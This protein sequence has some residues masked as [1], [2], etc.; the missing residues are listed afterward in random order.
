MDWLTH[1]FGRWLGFGA[2]LLLAQAGVFTARAE[3][4]VTLCTQE[5]LQAR[6]DEARDLSGDGLITFDCDGI[7]V[8]T[9]T[10][11]LPFSLIEIETDPYGESVTN[12]TE[13]LSTLTLDGTGR[14]ITLSGLTATNATNGVRLFLVD[15]GVTLALTNLT[16]INGQSTNGG[17][18]YVR[19]NGTLQ[20]SS[21]VFSNN[22]AVTSHGV[23]GTS[24]SA[25]T[26][27][28]SAK[29]GRSGTSSTTAAGGAIY[30]LGFAELVQCT[31]LTN[32]VVGGSGGKGG[33]GGNATVRGGDGGN[34]GKGGSGLGGA[35]Y[36]QNVLSASSSSFYFN[37]AFGGFGGDGG[38]AGSGPFAGQAGHG[39]SGGATAGAAI[40]SHLK[41]SNII[42]NSTFAF[43]TA[44]SGE[45]ANAGSNIGRG[46]SGPA[47]PNSS[48]G[49]LANLGTNRLINC[50]FFANGVVAGKGGNGADGNVQGGK[51]GSGGAAYG[52]NVFNG[53]K[54]ALM[55]ATNCT[56]SDGGAIPGTNGVAGTGPFAGKDGAQGASRGGN[57]ANSNGVFHLKNNLMAYPSHGTNGYG[58]FKDAGFN[59]SSDRSIKLNRKL[60]SI[61]NADPKL[62]ILRPNGG[63]VETMELLTGSRAIDAGDTNFVLSSDARGISRPLGARGDIGSYEAGVFLGPPRIVTHPVSQIAREDATIVF[64]VVAQGDPP[65]RYQWRKGTVDIPDETT[66]TLTL[67]GLTDDDAGDYLVVV[68]NN[69]GSINSEAATLVIVHPPIITEDLASFTNG[70][71]ADFSLSIT[72]EGDETLAYE[73]YRDGQRILGA[74]LSTLVVADPQSTADYYVIVRNQYGFAVSSTA[75]VTILQIAPSITTQPINFV[76]AVGNEAT[77]I[78]GT[79]GSRPQ[80]YQWYFNTTN[81]LVGAT[82]ALLRIFPAYAT[83]AGSYHVVVSNAVGSATS[84]NAILIVQTAKPTITSQP[85]DTGVVAGGTATFSVGV[86]GSAPFGYRW[87]FSTT[88]NFSGSTLV[89]GGT[90]AALAV[91]NAQ[92]TNVG[93]YRVIVTNLVGSITSAPAALTI[94]T[95]APVIQ[96]NPVDATIFS[97]E[98]ATFTVGHTGSAPLSYQWL[99]NGTALPGATSHP[100]VITNAQSANAGSYRLLIANSLGSVTSAPA[101]LTVSNSAPIITVQP[102]DVVAQ[103]ID[104]VALTVTAIGS[105]PLTFQWYRMV[106]DSMGLPVGGY[107]AMTNATSAT[108]TLPVTAPGSET[109]REGLYQVIVTNGLGSVSSSEVFVDIS[110]YGFGN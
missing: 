39:G 22:L 34:G 71:G 41:S 84:T 16:L 107:V 43:N 35:I 25:D 81:L 90:N 56:F 105:R 96:T 109:D 80:S 40:Y 30:N 55:L 100:L 57:I 95:S 99:L 98:T 3:S 45:S 103:D 106:I 37:F 92:T 38:A 17:A 102:A 52:G 93:F 28:G 20:V 89:T 1:I 12:E 23:D 4:I 66:D 32:G 60:G 53:G 59:F 110:G 42:V 65:L 69:S 97:G 33:D 15:S 88:T 44:A 9:N 78:V 31:F 68:S 24:A 72:A 14:F 47:G 46:K 73:W 21:C 104:I 91:T 50:T 36:N 76:V 83:N 2:L 74:T 10:I 5:E 18:I 87:Y 86:G 49:A 108:L 26:V 70:S 51:G 7:I 94:Q 67:F 61:T 48:G 13:L 58:T 6:I 62:D 75:R 19:S 54:R 77:F 82:N 8:L 85:A 79:S 64:S 29:D 63:P 101:V 11:V 27:N